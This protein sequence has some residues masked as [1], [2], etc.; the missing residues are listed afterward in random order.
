MLPGVNFKVHCQL[1]RHKVN[2]FA[3]KD[4]FKGCLHLHLSAESLQNRKGSLMEWKH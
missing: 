3:E 2:S 4:M 1:F